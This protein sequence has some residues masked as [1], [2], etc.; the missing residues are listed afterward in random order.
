MSTRMPVNSRIS[1]YNRGSEIRM[2]GRCVNSPRRDTGRSVPVPDHSIPTPNQETTDDTVRV[3]LASDRLSG[4]VALLDAEDA[5]LASQYQWRLIGSDHLYAAT[6]QKDLML[7]HRVVMGLVRGD[8]RM[9]DHI[10]GD[11]LDNRRANL[12]ICTN[13]QNQANRQR[14][15]ASSSRFRGVTWSKATT[16]WLASIKVEGHSYHLGSFAIEEDAAR[17]YDQAAVAFF[18]D[19]SRPNFPSDENEGA[20]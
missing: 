18:G 10:N 16:K 1:G 6:G 14:L 7:M 19:F 11:G 15:H 20:A 4:K 12:R 2:P 13:S 8:S 3:P 9:V 5:Y 17:A